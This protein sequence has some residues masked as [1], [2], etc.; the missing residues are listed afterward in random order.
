[1]AVTGPDWDLLSSYAGLLTLA[2]FSIYAGSYGSLP[3]PKSKGEGK[4][5]SDTDDDEEE[6][7]ERLSS[8]DAYLFPI[9]GS[10]V[11]FGLYLV[12]KYFGREW[13]TWLLQ[14]YFTVAG[15]GSVSKSLISLSRWVVGLSRWKQCEKYQLLFLKGPKE[16]ISFSVRT[17]SLYLMPLGALP[18]ILYT[19]GTSSTR[20]SALLTDILAL[21]F[22]HNALSLLKIDSFKTG[23][24]LLCGLFLYD[25]WW[26][27]GTEVMVKVA[28]SLDVPIKLLWPKSLFFSTER[29][30]T[31]LGLGDIVIP[32]MFIA[33]A[34]RYDYHRSSASRPYFWAALFAYVAGL[35]TTMFVMH[36]FKKAQPALLY[37]S[38]ACILSFIATALIRGELKEAWSWSDEPEEKPDSAFTS[39]IT[40]ISAAPTSFT[41]WLSH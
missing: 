26:V 40:D 30:F 6:E 21:S 25:V 22:S 34:L 41:E 17:P 8:T 35:G 18:S 2:S 14:W 5:T 11:L 23:C 20:R 16:I 9:I 15:V 32:G 31:M 10:V 24:V 19:F 38:P 7:T 13:I 29:G 12:L 28:T 39:M 37:L 3:N 33:L 1:M 36:F 4:L 27:F